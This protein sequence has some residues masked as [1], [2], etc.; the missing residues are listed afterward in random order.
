M[1]KS[2]KPGLASHTVY[3]SE[4]GCASHTVYDLSAGCDLFNSNMT[5]A[6]GVI[7]VNS[8]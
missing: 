5:E 1:Y 6:T 3:D 4:A 7:S 2:E 8:A